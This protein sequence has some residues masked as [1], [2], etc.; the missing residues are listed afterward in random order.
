MFD[1]EDNIKAFKLR[2][3]GDPM[4][5]LTE[6]L[7]IVGGGGTMDQHGVSKDESS[8]GVSSTANPPT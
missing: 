8:G 2:L 3:L 5:L 1:V 4:K 7:S 6:D